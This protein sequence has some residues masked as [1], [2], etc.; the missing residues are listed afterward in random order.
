MSEA[1]L[2]DVFFALSGE[3][4]RRILERL[5]AGAAT[6]QEIAA[7]FDV[8]LNTVSKHIK[9]LEHAGLIRREIRGREHHC[10]IRAEPMAEVAAFVRRYE[11]FWNARLDAMK[12]LLR[13]ARLSGEEE[14]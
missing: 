2:D 9:V 8:S 4:R 1:T 14:P 11:P 10:S 7:P 6:I 3:T 13:Q 5:T 12:G